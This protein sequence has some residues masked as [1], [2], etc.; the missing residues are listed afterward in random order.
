MLENYTVKIPGVRPYEVDRLNIVNNYLNSTHSFVIEKSIKSLKLK[1]L[2]F[3][4][5]GD[6]AYSN[7]N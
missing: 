7:A 6:K 3:V 2:Y 5:K 4:Q 1:L